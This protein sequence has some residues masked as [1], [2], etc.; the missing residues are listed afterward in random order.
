MTKRIVYNEKD[1]SVSIL[2]P[3]LECGMTVEEIAAAHVPEGCVSMIADMSELPENL[4]HLEAWVFDETKM[5][6]RV[7]DVKLNALMAK[8]AR[9]ERDS[10]LA[11]VIDPVVSN[12]LRWSSMK[13]EQQKAWEDYRQALLD[14]S[15]QADFPL[16]IKW[17]VQPEQ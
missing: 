7:D 3:V 5:T 14:I 10:I 15:K 16:E 4:D 6:V 13:P 1:G 9:H 11:Q 8:R 2:F 12:Q 17:P